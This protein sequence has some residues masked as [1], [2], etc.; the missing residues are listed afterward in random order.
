MAMGG[1]FWRYEQQL[2]KMLNR[3]VLVLLFALC[4]ASLLLPSYSGALE[5]VINLARCSLFAACFVQICKLLPR[6]SILTFI[7]QKSIAFYFMSGAIP[8]ILALLLRRVYSGDSVVVMLGM[9][10]GALVLSIVAVW[11]LNRY[12]PFLFDLRLLS[13]NRHN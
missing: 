12:L 2:E 4:L 3:P 10:G 7:G 9:F 1:V 8:N 13:K 5:L 6:I 11:L